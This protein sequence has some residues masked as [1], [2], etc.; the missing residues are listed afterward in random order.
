MIA[1]IEGRR[2][3]NVEQLRERLLDFEPGDAVSVTVLRNGEREVLRVRLPVIPQRVQRPQAAGAPFTGR[4]GSRGQRDAR[5]DAPFAGRDGFGGQ[6]ERL[7]RDA[8]QLSPEGRRQFMERL[9][10]LIERFAGS[11][12]SAPPRPELRPAGAPAPGLRP[13]TESPDGPI[14]ERLADL[15]A[16]RLAARGVLAASAPGATPAPEA[17]V[18]A[19]TELTAYF[20]RVVAIDA[21]S[22]TL[23]GTLGAVTLQLTPG[24]AYIGFKQAAAG[25]L[26]TAVV[27]GDVVQMLV[28]VG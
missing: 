11:F 24:T 8:R 18:A 9:T 14:L 6:V 22:V 10:D 2:V 19:P 17:S 27:L 23:T 7:F 15:V 3:T 25:D 5:P 26:V 13:A 21:N 20:G 4:D 1:G 12:E 28:V 16:E